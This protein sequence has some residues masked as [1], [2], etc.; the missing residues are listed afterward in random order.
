VGLS[1]PEDNFA[2]DTINSDII[3]RIPVDTEFCQYDAGTGR[4]CFV[5]VQQKVLGNIRF[6][7]TD[8]H[9]HPLGRTSHSQSQTASGTGANQSTLGNLSFS[10]VLR[11]DV[12]QQ[13][14]VQELETPPL[15]SSVPA[16]FSGVLKHQGF[17]VDDYGRPIGR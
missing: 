6:R 14:Q 15:Q 9:N 2:N 7:L 3:G 5:N 12:V 17:G 16:R 10:M 11:V 1:R 8:N 4:E 13:R